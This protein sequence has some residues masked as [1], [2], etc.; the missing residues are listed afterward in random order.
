MDKECG[1][2]WNSL[3]GMAVGYLSDK[4]CWYPLESRPLE[5]SGSHCVADTDSFHLSSLLLE[6]SWCLRYANLTSSPFCV[7]TLLFL[8]HSVATDSFMGQGAFPRLFSYV[9]G[10][11]CYVKT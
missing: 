1:A 3:A 11:F 4:M 2:L 6:I 5:T 9:N 7:D 10:S 8:L